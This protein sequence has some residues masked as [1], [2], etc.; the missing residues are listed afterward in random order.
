MRLKRHY[1][2]AH[3]EERCDYMKFWE[4]R[5]HI[6]TMTVNNK[7]A[8]GLRVFCLGVGILL[9]IQGHPPASGQQSSTL[10]SMSVEDEARDMKLTQI[11]EWHI[12]QAGINAL[13]DAQIHELQNEAKQD[14]SD[15]ASFHGEVAGGV[16]LMTILT[17]LA[18]FFQ[19]KKK[20]T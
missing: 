9:M 7:I 15:L 8:L 6:L 13:H 3:L 4:L 5:E 10:N 2:T 19:L 11:Q 12:E 14:A 16:G 18:V 1:S 17:G 20:G